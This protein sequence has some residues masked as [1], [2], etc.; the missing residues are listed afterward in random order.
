MTSLLR[1]EQQCHALSLGRGNGTFLPH[2]VHTISEA[3]SVSYAMDKARGGAL[4]PELLWLCHET[5]SLISIPC[6]GYEKVG[7][8]H[9]GVY[10]NFLAYANDSNMANSSSSLHFN[11]FLPC[12]LYTVNTEIIQPHRNNTRTKLGQ[13]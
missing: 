4:A 6:R 5:P 10:R 7:L 2:S 1:A 9:H 12:E 13:P 8:C 11:L 3:Q